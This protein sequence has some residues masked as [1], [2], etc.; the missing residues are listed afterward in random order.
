MFGNVKH[1]RTYMALGIAFL[2]NSSLFV[3]NAWAVERDVLSFVTR[4]DKG[5]SI[6]LINT[7]GELL[8][9][10]MIEG[11]IGHFTWSPDGR[12]IAY[13][14]NRDGD[15]YIYVMDVR[16]NTHRQLTFHDSRDLSP[17]WS[18][19]GKWIAFISERAGNRDIYRMDVNGG[20][21]RRLTNQGGCNKPVW[22]PDSQWIAFGSTLGEGVEID[23]FLSLMTAEGRGIRRIADTS[24][25]DCAWSS[26]GKEI[27]FVPPVDVVGGAALFSVDKDGK[28]RRQLTQLY[29]DLVLILNPI[30]SLRGKRIAYV[31]IQIPIEF[32][33]RERVPAEEL[34]AD[35]VIC[36]ANTEDGGGGEPIEATRELVYG[37]AFEWVPSGFLSV[38]LGAEKQTTLWSKLKQTDK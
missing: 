38:S 10:L 30:W 27:A 14:S 26:N 31:L 6:Q 4:K 37:S 32:L 16:T 12:S 13:S 25:P 29:K 1:T 22:S 34:F 20:N 36:I 11:P 19:N 24:Q 2:L 17:S 28:N 23:N 33:A 21:V 18:P 8:Q 3:S 7:R 9:R 15:P 5:H 35:S